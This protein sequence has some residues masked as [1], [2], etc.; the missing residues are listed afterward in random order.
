MS[1][2][3]QLASAGVAPREHDIDPTRG[4]VSDLAP[5]F[6]SCGLALTCFSG[7]WGNIGSLLQSTAPLLF[8]P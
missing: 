6:L 3:R 1:E 7:Q 8:S 5:Y 4:K 2:T